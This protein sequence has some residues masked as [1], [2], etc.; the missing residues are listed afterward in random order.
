MTIICLE[1]AVGRRDDPD[2][3]LDALVAAE[4]REL[5]VL[6]DV[7]ELGLQRR[8][9]LADFIEHQRAAVGLLE[10][11]D[12]RRRGAGERAAFVSEELALQQ[13]GR[14]RRAI[15]LDERTVA[16]GGAL[17]NRARHELLADPALSR[18]STVTSLSATCSMTVAMLRIFSLLPQTVRSSSS[19]SC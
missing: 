4:L 19:L 1:V 3:D 18:M 2:V 9:H 12:A 5:A 8:L 11:A 13:L 16:P 6:Q 7:Q 17:M 14:Q 15:H 10:L